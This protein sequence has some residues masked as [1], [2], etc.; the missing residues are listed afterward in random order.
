MTAIQRRGIQYSQNFL[1]SRYPVDELLDKCDIGL[2][3][4]IYE[5]GPGKGIMGYDDDSYN[6][7]P[8]ALLMHL[9]LL[10]LPI[11]LERASVMACA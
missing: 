6:F 11:L 2:N 4:I 9:L 5:I 8:F 10:K 3:D 1:K 7:G